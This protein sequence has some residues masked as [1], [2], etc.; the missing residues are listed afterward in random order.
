MTI[1]TIS[2]PFLSSVT[3]S[4]RGINTPEANPTVLR[5]TQQEFA[6]DVL[7]ATY[8]G[9]DVNS[10]SLISGSPMQA[11]FGRPSAMRNFYGY[12]NHAGR[13]NNNFSTTTT[14]ADR[15]GTTVVCVGASWPMKQTDTRSWSNYTASQII[16]EIATAFGLD[17]NIVPDTTMWPTQQMAGRTYWQFCVYLAQLIGYTFYCSGT[18]LV[19]KPRTTNPNSLASLAAIYDYLTNPASLPVFS[20]TV[21]AASP[22]GGELANRQLVGINPRTTQIVYAAA[23]GSL[24]STMLGAASVTP[25]FN[26]TEHC[27]VRSQEEAQTKVNGIGALNQLFIS[28]TATSAGNALIAQGS[29]IYVQNANGSQNGLWFVEKA[30]HTFNSQTYVIDLTL[31]RDS[32]GATAT[33]N[34]LPQTKLPPSAR[35]VSGSTWMAA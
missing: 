21:G 10:D 25:V 31:G 2:L 24:A 28:A 6:H 15:N 8:W 4:G 30:V 23:A 27:T 11:S 9:G 12:V 35:L 34:A 13:T 20:P 22:A 17:A 33:I 7:S 32:M 5:I 29:L 18:Q 3:F 26:K 19:F 1:S 16:Q 14:G